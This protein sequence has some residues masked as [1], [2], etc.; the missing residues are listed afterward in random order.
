MTAQNQ[1][2]Q[3]LFAVLAAF[4]KSDTYKRRRAELAKRSKKRL[5]GRSLTV[6]H[7]VDPLRK[8]FVLTR[9]VLSRSA[10]KAYV[11]TWN[12]F[13]D[14]LER[15][16]ARRTGR[17]GRG[18]TIER[19]QREKLGYIFMWLRHLMGYREFNRNNARAI[20]EMM[21]AFSWYVAAEAE[22]FLDRYT[23]WKAHEDNTNKWRWEV[24]EYLRK[25]YPFE[26]FDPMKL[27]DL[28]EKLKKIGRKFLRRNFRNPL[29]QDTLVKEIFRKTR[30]RT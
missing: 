18:L 5:S 20:E 23:F 6:L 26:Q 27:Y 12:R 8:P 15:A 11:Q 30:R 25:R 2:G 1:V 10:R 29:K 4:K 16:F 21:V 17:M 7:S 24:V 28:P 13:F 3:N 14:E 22:K 19:F 9:S